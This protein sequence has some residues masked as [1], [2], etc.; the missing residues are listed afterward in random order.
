MAQG[1]PTQQRVYDRA[2]A[3]SDSGYLYDEPLFMSLVGSDGSTAIGSGYITSGVASFDIVVDVSG[4][5]F[6]KTTWDN[7]EEAYLTPTATSIT[8]S[9]LASNSSDLATWISNGNSPVLLAQ[10]QLGESG[11]VFVG[12]NTHSVSLP[13]VGVPIYTQT[14]SNGKYILKCSNQFGGDQTYPFVFGHVE[15]DATEL[16]IITPGPT[17]VYAPAPTLA[18]TPNCRVQAYI[19]TGTEGY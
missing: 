3:L 15:I 12:P 7:A 11:G 6:N 19:S 16:G 2:L 9:F 10:L 17:P 13:G 4:C 18:E 8:L 5:Q 1:K 14:Q